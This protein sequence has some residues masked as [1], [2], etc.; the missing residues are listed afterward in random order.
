MTGKND[1]HKD[2]GDYLG[3]GV[4][5]KTLWA[6]IE[7]ALNKDLGHPDQLGDDPLVV[8]IFGEWGAG[9]STLL[10]LVEN[11]AREAAKTAAEARAQ[12][13]TVPVYFQ[14]WKYEHEKHLLVPLV[15]HVV[16]ATRE[17]L[18]RAPSLKDQLVALSKEADNKV[19]SIAQTAHTGIKTAR[20]WFPVL[21]KIAGS[22]SIFG[23]S[24]ALPDEIDDWLSDAEAVFASPEAKDKQRTATAREL[25]QKKLSFVDNGFH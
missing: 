16:E 5:A 2:K 3:Y 17:A 20:K 18:K 23:V 21:K 11:Q 12:V 19:V 25:R 24:I 4:Y 1:N 13:L 14:P 6:R 9:K 8:G 7:A 10:K 15:L 22:L